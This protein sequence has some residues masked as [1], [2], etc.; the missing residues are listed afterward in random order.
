MPTPIANN[1]KRDAYIKAV[2]EAAH[3]G[4]ITHSEARELVQEWMDTYVGRGELS[5]V[6]LA[7][8]GRSK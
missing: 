4:E 1:S 3:A 2:I 8:I 7:L 5:H 6:D